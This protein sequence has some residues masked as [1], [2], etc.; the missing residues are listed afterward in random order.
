MVVVVPHKYFSPLPTAVTASAAS[1]PETRAATAAPARETATVPE[2]RAAQAETGETTPG[3]LPRRRSKR[4]ETEAPRP[5]ERTDRGTVAA[6]PPDASF[7]GLA[8][9]ATAGRDAAEASEAAGDRDT[10]AGREYT[11]HRTEESD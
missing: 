11:E 8:A 3:G 6:V 7:S 5:A 1:A 9:F 2:P 4:N 10:L